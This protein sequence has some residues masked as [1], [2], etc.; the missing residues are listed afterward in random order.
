MVS[1]KDK[2][3]SRKLEKRDYR[4]K[5]NGAGT[6]DGGESCLGLA[7]FVLFLSAGS[8]ISCST[9]NPTPC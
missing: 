3:Q 4:L 1:K 6:G 8:C 5:E 2:Q 7:G 9:V